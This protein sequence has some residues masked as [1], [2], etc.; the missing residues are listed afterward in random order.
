[1][2]ADIIRTVAVTPSFESLG[3]LAAIILIRTFLSYSLQL[4]VTGRL[5]WQPERTSVHAGIR[6]QDG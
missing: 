1:M 3:V 2:A 5:P 4:D 6:P